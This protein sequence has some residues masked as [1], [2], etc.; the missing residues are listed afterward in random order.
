MKKGIVI[1][2]DA[3]MAL[4]IM[5]TMLSLATFYLGQVSYEENS[6]SSL[7]ESAMDTLNVLEKNGNLEYAV[8][9]DKVNVLRQYINKLP[10]SLCFDLT[11]Y[12]ATDSENALYAVVKG[13]CKKG[14]EDS[15]TINRSFLVKDISG[16]ADFYI[17]RM[18]VWRN[19]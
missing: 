15:A 6:N 18:S 19:F 8:Q 11:I 10:N 16:N 9:N 13:T 17:A 7:R 12:S 4:F 14:S 1:S 5:L 3:M 2:L